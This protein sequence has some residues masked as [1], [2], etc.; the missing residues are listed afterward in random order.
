MER[1]IICIGCPKGCNVHVEFEGDKVL[2]ITGNTCKRGEDYVRN[3]ITNP[4]RMV[5][6][7]VPVVG[8]TI[9][10][11]SVR[12]RS[13]IPKSKIFDVTRELAKVKLEAPVEIGSVIIKNV[14]DTGVDIIATKSVTE[15]E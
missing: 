15:A 10:A 13:D 4:M 6:S 9:A 12:T 7:I 5:T 1:D 11:V 2:S 8:G 14:A 3:E